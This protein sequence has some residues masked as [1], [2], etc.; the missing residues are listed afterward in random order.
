MVHAARIT[1]LKEKND[2]F[3]KI[4]EHKTTIYSDTNK[5]DQA[6]SDSNS[7]Y[8][9][10]SEFCTHNKLNLFSSKTD[11]ISYRT[12]I[13]CKLCLGNETLRHGNTGID[14]NDLTMN[15]TCSCKKT[16]IRVIMEFHSIT[17]RFLKSFTDP[18]MVEVEVRIVMILVEVII[19]LTCD[20]IRCT[21]D[22]D[23]VTYVLNRVE[24]SLCSIL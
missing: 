22:N 4:G 19:L 13:T 1:V 20:D 11:E 23:D 16:S 10:K 5:W 6:I 17:G 14:N 12:T 9:L 3:Y 24:L 2:Q 15:W 7:T 21:V 8:D 18:N